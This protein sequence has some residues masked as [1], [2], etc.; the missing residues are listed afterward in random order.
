M[1][2]ED[3]SRQQQIEGSS[4][5]SFGFVLVIAFAVVCAWPLAQGRAPRWWALLPAFLFAALAALRPHWL[6]WAN[7]LWTGLGVLLGKIVAPVALGVLFYGVLT[8]IGWIMRLAGKDPLRLR[9]DS[10]ASS[11]WIE[12]QPPGPPPDSMTHPY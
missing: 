5:R 8:P 6:G 4:N 2:H 11:Y 3:L 9:L 1:A 7:R 12:R 10:S